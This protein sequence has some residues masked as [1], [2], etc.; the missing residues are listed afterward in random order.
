MVS[1]RKQSKQLGIF[2]LITVQCCNDVDPHG[3]GLT[4]LL[5]TPEGTVLGT[6]NDDNDHN[7]TIKGTP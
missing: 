5:G 1:K 2:T 7:N 4:S 3:R 6:L